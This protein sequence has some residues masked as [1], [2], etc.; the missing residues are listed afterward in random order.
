MLANQAAN[1]QFFSSAKPERIGPMGLNI[2]QEI[3]IFGATGGTGAAIVR[4]A[5]NR[6]YEVTAFV[7]DIQ[8]AQHVFNGLCS[9]LSFSEGNALDAE[10]V[11]RAIGPGISAV[12]SALGIYQPLPGHDE[13]TTATQ[14]I[15]TAMR[16][17]G[18]R[19]FVCISSLGVGNSRN[20]GDFATRLIQKTALRFTLSDKEKQETAIHESELD[21]TVIRPSRLLDEGGPARYL[22]WT[23]EQ[24]DKELVWSINRAQVAALTLDALEN[25]QCINQALNVTGTLSAGAP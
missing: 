2:K 24:P 22:T 9:H 5:V 20:Q 18:P 12:V 3:L 19:R 17:N 23:G 16:V 4:E 8:H 15:L 14:N 1:K 6:G 21:W 11:R 25:D 13:L 7:R 10:D